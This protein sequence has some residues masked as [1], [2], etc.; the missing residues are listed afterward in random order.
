ML[1]ILAALLALLLAPAALA[2]ESP[3]A[4]DVAQT[5]GGGARW[6]R[7]HAACPADL[8]RRRAAS[9]A[10]EA[11][12]ETACAAVPA[13]C[14]AACEAG[15]GRACFKLARVYQE[16][17]AHPSRVWERLFAAACAGGFAAGCTNRAAG[18]R[19]GGYEDDPFRRVGAKRRDACL[20]RSF[21]RACSGEDVWGCAMLGQSHEQGEG[22]RRSAA[23]ARR[24]YE[25][26]CD[27]ADDSPACTFARAGLARL[28]R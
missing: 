18:V 27:L 19:N 9:P 22:G 14:L 13:G 6:A 16:G 5:I 7:L 28:K 21:A 11:L 10:N 26:A 20:R 24:A 4:R 12:D 15:D 1:R 2:Q 23:E 3:Q 17:K 25:K 8:P